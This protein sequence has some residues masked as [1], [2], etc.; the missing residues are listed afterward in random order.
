MEKFGIFELLDALSALS[1]AEDGAAGSAGNAAGG[2]GTDRPIAAHGLPSEPDKKN[3][4]IDAFL[5]RH[6]ALSKKIDQN[7]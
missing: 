2:D 1:A 4:A 7:K 5:S 3:A 6:E